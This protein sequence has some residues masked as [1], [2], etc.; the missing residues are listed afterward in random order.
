MKFRLSVSL[1]AVLV[2][3]QASYAQ[4]PAPRVI[5]NEPACPTCTIAVQNLVTLGTD[6]GV[7]S[8][9][10][11][12]M[13]V[14]VDSK[15]RYW[16]FQ[17]LEPPTVFT[18]TGS[19]IQMVGRKGR[20]PGEF[21]AANNGLVLGDSMLA[22]DWMESRATMI[23]P[24]LKAGRTIRIRSGLSNDLIVL[25]W[26]NLLM[27]RGYFNDSKPANSTLHRLAFTGSEMQ[28][29]GSFGPRGTGGPMG[30]VDVGQIIG[31]ARDGIWSTYWN[32]PEFAKW[33]RNGVAQLTLTRRLDW[34]TPEM[35]GSMGTPTTPPKPRTGAIH[36]D[37]DGL[38]W[39][40]IHTPA[41]T[42]REG[43]EAPP[44]VYPGG[45]TEYAARKMGYDK[46]FRTYVEVIDPVRA[47][48]VT[49]TTINGY[50]FGTLPDQ[51][52]ALYKVDENG[53]PRVQIVSLT[54]TG[55]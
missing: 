34:Y 54:L 12:P 29:L 37:A 44:T 46:L 49:T 9:N 16:V 36:E 7:G 20:G 26:P 2:A 19:V 17:E 33:D 13:S 10:G 32:R 21:Q 23:G 39:L 47:R 48:V 4:T 45:G 31:R 8:L 42:W 1:A 11:K 55:R 14:N 35:K 15:G 6:D 50:V 51:R 28:L 53:I 38:V 22:F 18:A 3:L 43:W 24:D 40:F 30:N 52:V 41:P 25:S 27:A 5:P